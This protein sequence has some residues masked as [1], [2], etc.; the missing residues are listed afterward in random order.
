MYR[1]V[2]TFRLV[3][4][5]PFCISMLF[6]ATTD[7]SGAFM[8]RLAALLLAFSLAHSA[9]A[10][11]VQPP[12]AA[13]AKPA[14]K[15]QAPPKAAAEPAAASGPCIGVFPLL[16]DQFGVRKIGMTVFGNDFKSIKV[17]NW[18][19]DDLVVERLRAAVAPG[20]AVRRIAYDKALFEGYV[21][22]I[23]MFQNLDSKAPAI[24]RQ[25]AARTSCERYVVVT[26]AASQYV[27]NQSIY[28]LGVVNSGSPV[29]T[30]IAL[31]AVVRIHVHDGHTFAVVKSGAG[32]LGGGSF[33]SGPAMR[34]LDDSWW[35]EPPE[36]ANTPRMRDAAR[37]L[38]G[39]VLDKS[40][41][42]M[43]AK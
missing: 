38:L 39:E 30:T 13:K 9:Q 26:R 18:G 8:V 31:H 14:A 7:S 40:L 15:K 27:G 12:T 43:L 23:G 28:G 3:Y 34:K 1:L 11:T 19:L 4:T 6:S 33:L 36:A 42:E 22:G 37:K 29:L 16:S 32:S 20:I 41:P 25:A 10:Q 17:D 5:K 35:P 2:G 21:P 24:V